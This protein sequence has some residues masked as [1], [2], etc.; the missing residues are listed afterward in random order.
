MR[1]LVVLLLTVLLT[2]AAAEIVVRT[3][4]R[5]SAAEQ[6]VLVGIAR[7]SVDKQLAVVQITA[8]DGRTKNAT[9]IFEPYS[10]N[11]ATFLLDSV[12]CERSLRTQ[13]HCDKPTTRRYL[14]SGTISGSVRIDGDIDL[15]VAHE[16]IEYSRSSTCP[17]LSWSEPFNFYH[18]LSEPWMARRSGDT[19]WLSPG[20]CVL[21]MTVRDGK[22]ASAEKLSVLE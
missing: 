21:Q 20:G 4:Y 2:P 17:P 15:D 3:P 16:L 19:Y 22:V 9:V 10:W 18:H 5:L 14:H 1:Q 7:A 6:S 8:W 13:W 12:E 11:S